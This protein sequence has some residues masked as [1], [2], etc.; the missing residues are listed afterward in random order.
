M[1][2][3]CL[4]EVGKEASTLFDRGAGWLVYILKLYWLL[5]PAL[6]LLAG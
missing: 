3:V 5:P 4:R 6:S 2:G 1:T